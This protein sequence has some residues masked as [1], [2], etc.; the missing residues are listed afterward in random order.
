MAQSI[1]LS[2]PIFYQYIVPNGYLTPEI[3]VHAL[4]YYYLCANKAMRQ[5]ENDFRLESQD[6]P[7][8]INYRQIFTSI[9][10]MY[11]VDTEKMNNCWPQIDKQCELLNLP[12]LP[13]GGDR[14]NDKLIILIS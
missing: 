9:A 7:M 6:M 2:P 1:T 12:K 10:H 8:E 4:W 5:A 11:N 14:R 13:H 3:E